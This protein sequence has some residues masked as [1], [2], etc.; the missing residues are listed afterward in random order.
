MERTHFA[1]RLTAGLAGWFQQLAAQDL[2][3]QV[4]E[5]AARVELVRMISAQRAFV[6]DTSK[7]PTNWPANDKRRIDVAVLGRREGA[8]GWYG[9]IELK[10]PGTSNDVA[11][12]RLEMVQDAIRVAFTDT[13]NM[14]A[15]F[16]MLGGSEAA[17]HRVFEKPH[18][19]AADAEAQRI[20][21][22]SLFSR[23]LNAPKGSLTNA[24]LRQQ[25]PAALDRIDPAVP[26]GW[27]RRFATQLIAVS[28]ARVGSSLKGQVFIWQCRK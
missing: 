11:K 16:F 12:L 22:G 18:P 24:E 9:A 3:L 1:E 17:I 7:R 4:G 25:F 27:T 19:G 23:D 21:F 28:E 20:A 10:W 2:H 26:D 8:E 6:P 14:N 15:R 5:D 13:G